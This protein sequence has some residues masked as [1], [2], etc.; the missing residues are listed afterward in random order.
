VERVVR[1]AAQTAADVDR[2]GW[3]DYVFSPDQGGGPR[4][5]AGREVRA[6]HQDG[7][8]RAYACKVFHWERTSEAPIFGSPLD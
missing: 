6:A 4:V 7:A 8:K 5:R 2:D 1:M 3:E